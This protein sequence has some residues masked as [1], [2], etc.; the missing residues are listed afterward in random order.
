VAKIRVRFA[1]SPTGSIHIGNARTAL[2]NY[3]YAKN[4]GGKFILRIEDTD[5]ERS[6]TESESSLLNS[7]KRLGI[8]WDEG[9]QIGGEYGPY[10]QSEKLD[11]YRKV[12]ED[13]VASGAAYPCYCSPEE[14]EADRKVMQAANK[15]PRYSGKCRELSISER[16]LKETDGAKP[17]YRFRVTGAEVKFSDGVRGK[18]AFKAKDIG[19]FIIMRADGVAAFYLASSV[20]DIDMEITDVIRGEDHLSNT[21]KQILI[22]RAMGSEPPRFSHL[23]IILGAD[24]QKLSKRTGSADVTELLDSGYLPSAL[25]TAMAM[26]GWSKVTGQSAETLDEMAEKF[27]ISDVSRSPAKYDEARL[28]NLNSK[29]LKAL[30]CVKLIDFLTP[31]L[32]ALNFPFEKF[33]DET[34]YK[35]MDATRDAFGKPS[36]A[37]AQMIL[38]ARLSEPDD[39]VTEILDSPDFKPVAEALLGAIEGINSFTEGEYKAVIESVSLKTGLKGKK[40]FQ[41]VRIVLTGSLSGPKLVD[42]F[43]ILEADEIKSRINSVL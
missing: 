1:P 32:E 10:R 20:D 34:L 43:T 31:A 23:P 25:N 3:L 18:V 29:A 33:N 24:G 30:P 9:P 11:R 36:D 28:D 19:D 40:L 2:F 37:A 13:M 21:P 41:P 39:A 7:I 35:I 16:E 26:L 15:P 4:K 6:T 12:A 42:L 14:L 8:E 38:F 17:A 27:Y 22:M 5:L